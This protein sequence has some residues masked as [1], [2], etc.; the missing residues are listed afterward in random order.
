MLLEEVEAISSN[1][2]TEGTA[3]GGFKRPVKRHFF[4]LFLI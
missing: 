1:C 4:V 2:I 3:Y